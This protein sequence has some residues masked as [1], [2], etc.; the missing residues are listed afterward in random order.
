MFGPLARVATLA[1]IAVWAAA[2]C[3]G[4]N[5]GSPDGGGSPDA[6]ISSSALAGVFLGRSWTAVSGIARR[7]FPADAGTRFV[8]LY[9]IASDCSNEPFVSTDREILTDIPWQAAVAYNFSLSQNATFTYRDDA[10]QIQND[11]TLDGRIEVISAPDDAGSLG[12]LRI[13]A[14]FDANNHVEGQTSLMAC[15][16]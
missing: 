12:A 9:E 1:A 10:G 5:G 14:T 11:V 16:F 15:D 6:A 2:A 7:D 8:T 4:G 13:R 3:G